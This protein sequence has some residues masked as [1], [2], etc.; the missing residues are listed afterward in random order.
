MF[1]PIV[2]LLLLL[3]LLGHRIASSQIDL[4]TAAHAA[5]RAATLETSPAAAGAA[6]TATAEAM[7]PSGCVDYDVSAEVGGLEPGT[8]VTVTLAC[9]TRTVDVF[10][11]RTL[12]ATSTS[13]VDQ[14]SS[15]GEQP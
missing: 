9:T 1:A 14:W 10:G 11:S 15:R 6:A 8:T 3:G 4:Q 5:A 2:V 12:T 7:R 13:P